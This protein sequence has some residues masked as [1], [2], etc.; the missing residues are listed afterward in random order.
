MFNEV[1][2]ILTKQ[3]KNCDSQDFSNIFSGMQSGQLGTIREENSMI[4]K[5][6][7]PLNIKKELNKMQLMSNITKPK[8]VNPITFHDIPNELIIKNLLF[9]VD[10]NSLPRIALACKK[11]SEAVKTHI[12]IRL[13]FLNKEKKLIEADNNEMIN[14]IE[15]KRKNFFEEYE[16]DPPNKDHACQLMNTLTNSHITEL[17]QV[18]KKYN[19]NY[20][21][22]ISPLVL[23][24]G[25]KVTIFLIYRHKLPSIQ[26]ALKQYP[27]STQPRSF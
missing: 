10:I 5:V 7:K 3:V 26:M 9:F 14:S 12:F 18:F 8:K 23:L 1:M 2:K 6:E 27:T 16:I 17:K 21:N 24:M 11:T 20:E 19:K 15:N 25:H 22:I 4:D 13:F